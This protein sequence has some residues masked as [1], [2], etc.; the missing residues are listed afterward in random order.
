M[1]SEPVTVTSG[2]FLDVKERA[3]NEPSVAETTTT[4]ATYMG[5]QG[6]HSTQHRIIEDFSSSDDLKVLDVALA[7]EAALRAIWA[8]PEEDEAWSDL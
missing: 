6:P 5:K 1:S 8:T 4:A 7:S 3:K 2:D